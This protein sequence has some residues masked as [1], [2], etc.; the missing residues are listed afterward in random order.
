MIY[1]IA[2]TANVTHISSLPRGL[3]EEMSPAYYL[4]HPL[5]GAIAIAMKRYIACDAAVAFF[6]RTI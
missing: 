6:E 1:D 2:I 3:V 4:N 5:A